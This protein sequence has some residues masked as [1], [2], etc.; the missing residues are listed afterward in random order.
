MA[1]SFNDSP[2][3]R[4]HLHTPRGRGSWAFA[5]RPNPDV[6]GPGVLWSPSMT[7][8]EACAWARRQLKA[9]GVTDCVLYVLP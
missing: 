3:R 7:Y 9:L 5:D 1:I 2:F 8:T 4:S 6:T